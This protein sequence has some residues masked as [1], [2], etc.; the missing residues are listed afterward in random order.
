[1]RN[2]Q[3]CDRDLIEHK[4]VGNE[5]TYIISLFTLFLLRRE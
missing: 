2:Q 3:Q 4:L 5:N 1:M